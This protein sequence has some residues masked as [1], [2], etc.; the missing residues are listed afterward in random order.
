M[1]LRVVRRIAAIPIGRPTESGWAL[2][3]RTSSCA[4]MRRASEIPSR[5][6]L[7]TMKQELTRMTLLLCLSGLF[8]CVGA[9]MDER[10][11]AVIEQFNTYRSELGV[12]PVAPDECL[13]AAAH[14]QAVGLQAMQAYKPGLPRDHSGLDQS[15]IS[16]RSRDHGCGDSVAEISSYGENPVERWKQSPGHDA[17]MRSPAYNRAGVAIVGSITIAV[18]AP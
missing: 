2:T 15:E 7:L 17:I 16:D 14:E 3:H 5:Y 4:P 13:A 11:L 9:R 10:E 8:G 18:F 1:H 6:G 12:Q